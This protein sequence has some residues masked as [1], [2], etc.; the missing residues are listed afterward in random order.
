MKRPLGIKQIIYDC[1]RFW[2]F[3]FNKI[4]AIFIPEFDDCSYDLYIRYLG[5]KIIAPTYR[6]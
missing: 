4:T 6:D 1:N 5:R 3:N 2:S